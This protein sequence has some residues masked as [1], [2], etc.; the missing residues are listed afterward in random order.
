MVLKCCVSGCRSV[1]SSTST[2]T[3]GSKPVTFI[4]FPKD[5]VKIEEWINTIPTPNLKVSGTT[6]VYK[7]F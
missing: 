2:D 1:L 7:T 3:K 4:R 5:K 6:R